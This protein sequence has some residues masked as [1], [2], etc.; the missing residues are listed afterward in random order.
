MKKASVKSIFLRFFF[1]FSCFILFS[2]C[3][4]LFFGDFFPMPE[5]SR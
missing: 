1:D 4:L 3:F 2:V 5:Y